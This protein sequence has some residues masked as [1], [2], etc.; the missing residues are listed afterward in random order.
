[1]VNKGDKTNKGHTE[2]HSKETT[3]SLNKKL[4]K[5]E[6]KFVSKNSFSYFKPIT[7]SGL[8]HNKK[9]HKQSNI[10]K[11]YEKHNKKSNAIQKKWDEK[12]AKKAEKKKA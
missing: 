9:V 8:K 6:S 4:G 2:L 5:L 3:K 11:K 1:M 10:I 7:K 12:A